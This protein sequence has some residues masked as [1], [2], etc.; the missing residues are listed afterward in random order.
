MYSKA[1]FDE[2]Y[3]HLKGKT[4]INL[5][6]IRERKK[7]NHDHYGYSNSKHQTDTI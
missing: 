2:V 7:D 4:F 6:I 1:I 5:N 3:K